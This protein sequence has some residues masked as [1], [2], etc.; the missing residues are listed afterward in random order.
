MA[1]NRGS[2]DQVF[3]FVEVCETLTSVEE[4]MNA[5][6]PIVA[7]LVLFV[8]PRRAPAP[9]PTLALLDSWPSGCMERY[10]SR[11]YFDVNPVG[12][13][14]LA[15]SSPLLWGNAPDRRDKSLSRKMLVEA[16]EFGLR[17]RFCVPIHGATGW[18]SAFSF[19]TTAKSTPVPGNWRPLTFS[20]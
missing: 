18:Q 12:Q 14:V 5:I 19:A 13:N 3:E 17:D 6:R 9:E 11:N 8:H 7:A 16:A 10:S 4:C 20:P 15:T 2:T 1:S